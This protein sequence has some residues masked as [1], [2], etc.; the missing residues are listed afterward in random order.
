MS[1]SR[2][3]HS[4]A[5]EA[6]VSHSR[7]PFNVRHFKSYVRKFLLVLMLYVPVNNFSVMSGWFPV[8]LD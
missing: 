3:Q 6:Q 5:G 8:F 1:N 4:D 7:D 2:T